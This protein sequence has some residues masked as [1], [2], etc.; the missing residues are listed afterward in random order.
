MFYIWTIFEDLW[1]ESKKDGGRA[2]SG[3]EP[4]VMNGEARWMLIFDDDD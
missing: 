3:D 1:E 4:Y 2:V